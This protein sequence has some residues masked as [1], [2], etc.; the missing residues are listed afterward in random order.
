MSQPLEG[1]PIRTLVDAQ[2][3]PCGITVFES[4]LYWINTGNSSFSAPSTT[5]GSTT[6]SDGSIVRLAL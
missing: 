5:D 1:G 4:T 2:D 6:T 3:S